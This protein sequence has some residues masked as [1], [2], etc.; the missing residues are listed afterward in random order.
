M[1]LAGARDSPWRSDALLWI[2]RLLTG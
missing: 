1:R 2:A